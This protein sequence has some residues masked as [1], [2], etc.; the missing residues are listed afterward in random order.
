M[1][2]LAL[3]AILLAQGEEVALKYGTEKSGA[4][5]VTR[6]LKLTLKLEGPDQ[7]LGYVRSMHQFLSMEK[8]MLRA[9]GTRQVLGG[10][11]QRIDHGEARVEMRYDD[12]NYELDYAKGQPI[13]KDKTRQMMWY[14]AAAGA[15]FTLSADGEYS[16]L[17]DPN[18]DQNGEAMDLIAM[19]IVRM[20]GKPVREGDTYEQKWKGQRSEKG[21]KGV[22]AFA[23]KVKV[24]KIESRDGK[25]FATLAAE[26]TGQVEGGQKDPSAEE[27][28][29][30]CEG[31]IKT[32]IE[33]G[34][35]RV[36]SSEG[37][38]KVVVYHRGTSDKGEKQE[39]TLTFTVE[40]KISP[41]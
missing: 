18:Q 33:V 4:D 15:T 24:E 19:G 21:K 9:E 2:R 17:D 20:P 8:L 16:K 14:F 39:L 13:E 25:K 26:L 36:V 34:T 28:W 12:E 27:A 35:G 5:K 6:E 11:K 40:G 29:N 37:A 38:G 22:Y 23:Q 31:R 1:I 3:T 30:K 32:V 7:L 41:R 10:R